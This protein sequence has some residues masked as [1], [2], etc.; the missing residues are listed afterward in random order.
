MIMP[1]LETSDV[2]DLSCCYKYA[3]VLI[4]KGEIRQW[5]KY[6]MDK[7]DKA[8]EPKK[9]KK[10]GENKEGEGEASKL[11]SVSKFP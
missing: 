4:D 1:S 10:K 2:Y 9:P 11:E 5:G 6:L 8:D 3:A 7:Q